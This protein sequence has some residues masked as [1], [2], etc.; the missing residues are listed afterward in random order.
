[1]PRVVVPFQPG[2]RRPVLVTDPVEPMRIL[3]TGDAVLHGTPEAPCIAAYEAVLVS[4]ELAGAAQGEQAV[5]P[6]A[7]PEHSWLFRKVEALRDAPP[8]LEYRTMSCRVD[9][10]AEVPAEVFRERGTL[11]EPR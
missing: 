1:T 7:T 10:D 3:L 6:M 11:A 2:T 8:S 5:V 9:R 4:S